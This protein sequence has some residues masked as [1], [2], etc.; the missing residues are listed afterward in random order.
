MRHRQRPE[1]G[2]QGE[3]DQKVASRHLLLQLAFEP[4]LT[5]MV[6]A[7]RAMAVAAGV[8][9]QHLLR[10]AAALHLHLGAG[11]GAAAFDGCQ[12]LH[13]TGVETVT[14]LRAEVLLEG[15]DDTGEPDHVGCS[16]L[17]F[18]ALTFPPLTCPQVRLKPSISVLM[19]SIAWCLVLSVR[20][21]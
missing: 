7:V 17:D 12:R 8:R 14:V 3:G 19:R 5:L 21:V 10:A 18:P 1:L 16:A 11:L 9:H 2:R 13:V 4:L 15:V 20:W 6:L